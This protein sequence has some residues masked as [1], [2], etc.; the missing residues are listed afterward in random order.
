MGTTCTKSDGRNAIINEEVQSRRPSDK[1]R[2][3]SIK[4][5]TLDKCSGATHLEKK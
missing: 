1:K 3:N 2:E 5:M 4:N